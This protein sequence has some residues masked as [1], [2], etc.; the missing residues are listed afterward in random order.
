MEVSQ[1][2]EKGQIAISGVSRAISQ[3][4]RCSPGVRMGCQIG[5]LLPTTVW[6][7]GG[8]AWLPNKAAS[9]NHRA[10]ARWF[11]LVAK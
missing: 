6:S 3:C 10:A 5:Q 8:S 9:P 11:G 7:P 2:L 4:R 1:S